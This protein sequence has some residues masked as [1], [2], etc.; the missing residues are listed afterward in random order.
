MSTIDLT[1]NDSDGENDPVGDAAVAYASPTMEWL[2]ANVC[3]VIL[4]HSE[5][6]QP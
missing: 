6:M 1:I 4:W 3:K 2:D 5:L